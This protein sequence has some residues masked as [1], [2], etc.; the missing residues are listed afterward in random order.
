MTDLL[1]PRTDAGV[2]FQVIVVTVVFALAT[3]S[4]RRNRDVRILMVGMWVATYGFMGVR[5]IH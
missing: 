4:F 5:A 1:L 3:I 2:L